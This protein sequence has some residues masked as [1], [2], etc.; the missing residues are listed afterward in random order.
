MGRCA[1]LIKQRARKH[2]ELIDRRVYVRMVPGQFPGWTIP[3]MDNSR[4]TV[5][6][7]ASL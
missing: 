1:V 3:V 6:H 4:D 7:I 5:P 2:I